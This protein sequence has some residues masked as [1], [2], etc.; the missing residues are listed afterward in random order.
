MEESKQKRAITFAYK[1]IQQKNYDKLMQL[2]DAG[3]PDDCGLDA[4][5]NTALGLFCQQLDLVGMQKMLERGALLSTPNKQGR[6][7]LHLLVQVDKTG[8]ATEWLLSI[9]G[10]EGQCNID[11]QSTNGGV[12]PLM[13]AIKLN[14][15]KVVEHLLNKGANPF[16]KDHLGQEAL[17]YK[18]ATIQ[19]DTTVNPVDQMIALAK[20]QWLQQLTQEQID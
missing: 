10:I 17:D 16:L 11:Y 19:A 18:V 7:P 13:L 6:V 15:E 5:D 20:E 8:Q 3:L 4:Q 1:F 12:T 2:F 14:H 9:E